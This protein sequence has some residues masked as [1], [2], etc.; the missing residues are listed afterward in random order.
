MRQPS[1]PRISPARSRRR[2]PN[3]SAPLSTRSGHEAPSQDDAGAP[4]TDDAVAEP[5]AGV[6]RQRAARRAGSRD[7]AS[8][9]S[10]S[11][12]SGTSET[13]VPGAASS[14]ASAGAASTRDREVR[15]RQAR[16][17]AAR[18]Q[19]PQ[20]GEVAEGV[21]EGAEGAGEHQLAGAAAQRLVHGQLAVGLVLADRVASRSRRRRPPAARGRCRQRVEVA[22]DDVR[23]QSLLQ[24]ETG[25]RR[26]PR[27]PGRRRRPAAGSSRR[28]RTRRRGT[29]R[30]GAAD[31]PA[32]SRRQ[33][34]PATVT[35]SVRS[36]RGPGRP[37]RTP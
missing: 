12:P 1:G 27:P 8:V 22:D 19:A 31:R 15:R 4:R 3:V 23:P 34:R 18:R 2:P 10:A 6:G 21:V 35:R 36:G 32:S 25:R 28:P 30:R 17:D 20:D 11:S 5:E 13:R 7:P 14:A 9:T 29:R 37:R 26:R 33:P 16:G 24:A